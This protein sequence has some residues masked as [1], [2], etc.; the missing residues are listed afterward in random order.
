MSMNFEKPIGIKDVLPDRLKLQ[1]AVSHN[2]KEILNQWGYEEIDT[3]LIEYHHTVG[4]YS[5]IPDEKLIKFLDPFGKTVILRPDFTTP[6]ARFVASTYKD[7]DFPI[8]L[9]YEGK[10]FI[11]SGSKGIN[12]KKQIGMELIGFPSLDADA[13][14][15]CLAVRTILRTTQ[16]KFKVAV[17]HTKL[18][19]LLLKQMG[20][21]PIIYEQLSQKLLVH[22]Y[23]AYKEIVN[24]LEIKDIFKDWL[25]RIL[26]MRGSIENIIEAQA[27]FNSS[28]WQEIFEEMSQLWAALQEYKVADYVSF[29]LSLLGQQSYYTGLI[30]HVFCE[31]NP[32][33]ICSGGRY[34]NLLKNFG[35]PGPATGF[36]INLDDLLSVIK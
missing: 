30:Y 5:K 16:A 31:G 21:S 28:E 25:L 14:V 36:A 4:L 7:V 34:D 15:I 26:K 32:R 3:P 8:R 9:M 13:E 20:C 18:L 2:I 22:D 17:G 1:K 11:N 29:D 33:P 27:W 35:R 24:S 12:E 10:V 6:I 19:K 23:V